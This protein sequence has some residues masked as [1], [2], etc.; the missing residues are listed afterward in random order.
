MTINELITWRNDLTNNLRH[1][2]LRDKFTYEE[3][4]EFNLSLYRIEEEMTFFYGEYITTDK[5]LLSFHGYET[6]Q[7]KIHEFA[8][9]D[10][11]Y[12]VFEGPIFPIIS[13]NYMISCGDN[14]SPERVVKIEE[15]I[16]TYIANADEEENA[17]DLAAWRHDLSWLSDW[18]KYWLEDYYGKTNKKR[19]IR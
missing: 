3:K 7:D 8:R 17:V 12:S 9:T 16:G 5:D 6:G 19:R 2:E 13:E 15:I 14:K 1:P 18:K 11:I 10:I 4:T